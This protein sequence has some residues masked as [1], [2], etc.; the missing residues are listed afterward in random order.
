MGILLNGK[1]F[2]PSLPHVPM[3]NER[4]MTTFL[5]PKSCLTRCALALAL[6]LVV[7]PA[8]AGSE[9]GVPLAEVNGQ[10][11]TAEDLDHALGVKLTELQEQI[12]GRHADHGEARVVLDQQTYGPADQR[13][14]VDHE[15]PYALHV[16][17]LA[18]TA[19]ASS[20]QVRRGR[21]R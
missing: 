4:S 3:T 17:P 16:R 20:L 8:Q 6:A 5:Q 21:A 12:L 15:D 11:V 13:R 1:A 19:S 2:D 9:I 10:V 14:V 7:S 18:A